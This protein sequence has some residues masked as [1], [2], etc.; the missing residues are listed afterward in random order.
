MLVEQGFDIGSGAFDGCS[1]RPMAAM[2]TAAPPWVLRIDSEKLLIAFTARL[3]LRPFQARV[4][5]Y[6][7]RERLFVDLLVLGHRAL[8]VSVFI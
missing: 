1:P 6:R 3:H 4:R 7:P 8:S 2:R 5:G